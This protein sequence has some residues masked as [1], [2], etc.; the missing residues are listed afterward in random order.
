MLHR[1]LRFNKSFFNE[2]FKKSFFHRIVSEWNSLPIQIRD[3]TSVNSFKLQLMLH[4]KLK[5]QE[6]ML[7]DTLLRKQS[8][9]QRVSPCPTL[10][11]GRLFPGSLSPGLLLAI[12]CTI[13]YLTRWKERG[14]IRFI[15]ELVHNLASALALRAPL[16]MLTICVLG[17]LLA[18]VSRVCAIEWKICYCDILLQFLNTY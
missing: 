8:T 14:T 16:V 18:D 17:R 2:T 3:S 5:L 6:L 1:S 12:A 4:Y 9:F 13:T 7:T 11:A 15:P 10:V